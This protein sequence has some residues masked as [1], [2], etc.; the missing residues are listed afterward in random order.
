MRL[1]LTMTALL[2]SVCILSAC[3]G[4]SAVVEREYQKFAAVE[5][6]S[7]LNYQKSMAEREVRLNHQKSVADY[8]NCLAHNLSNV[9]LCEAQRLA[10]E[11]AFN[12]LSR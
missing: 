3:A 4:S 8:Q 5:R 2:V 11:T 9:D 1:F 7:R 12:N 10:M 6:E